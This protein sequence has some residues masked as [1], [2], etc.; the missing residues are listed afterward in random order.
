MAES[1]HGGIKRKVRADRRGLALTHDSRINE[2][3][4]DRPGSLRP[5]ART[6][7]P[8]M[9]MFRLAPALLAA[10]L[11]LPAAAAQPGFGPWS[12]GSE[13]RVR[14][15]AAGVGADGRLAGGIE[16]ML[17]P[18]WW[19]YWRTPG[20]A[21]I[22][23]TIDFSGSANLGAVEVSFPLPERHDN[24]YGASNVYPEGVLLPF[25]AVIPEPGEAVE[26]R[27]SLDLGVCQEVCIPEH[28]EAALSL[29]PGTRDRVAAATLAGARAQ[30]PGEPE[31]GHLAVES[32]RRT[33]GPDK[34]PVFDLVVTAPQ[35][36]EVF[37]E[38]PADWFPGV[39]E[40]VAE[41][42]DGVYRVAVDRLGSKTP[43]EGASLRVTLAADGKA[44]EQVI[45]ID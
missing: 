10:L 19:T 39:P 38:G 22:P 5:A 36:V 26:L 33:G 30:V 15:V 27:L 18:G 1:Y 11:A 25:S 2:A 24:G 37:V 45:P 28:V 20:A 34:R 13:A 40:R 29:Q 23:P 32:A 17:E 4:A 21:G 12:E 3:S 44:V 9:T 14:L 6:M 8:P 43:V 16:I 42:G 7:V 31:P 35:G 41:A